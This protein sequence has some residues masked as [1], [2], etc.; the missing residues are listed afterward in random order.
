[1]QSALSQSRE[2]FC[3]REVKAMILNEKRKK[4][5][6]LLAAS[7]V[8]VC[9]LTACGFGK[10]K[11]SAQDNKAAQEQTAAENGTPS[12]GSEIA[13]NSI[14]NFKNDKAYARLKSDMEKGDTP[15][16]CNVLFDVG[17]ARPDVTVTDEAKIKEIYDQLAKI[18]VGEKS[19]RSVTAGKRTI[20]PSPEEAP[21]GTL[22]GACRTL[23]WRKRRKQ[24]L[25]DPP[26]KAPNLPHRLLNR[27][28]PERRQGM[29]G[30]QARRKK[31]NRSWMKSLPT[32]SPRETFRTKISQAAQ[33]RRTRKR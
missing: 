18:T 13:E 2:T 28:L 32:M 4:G 20:M 29:Q 21:C 33:R 27:P 6:R 31:R 24:L 3:R 26:Q 15:I 30:M 12:T 8:V 11:E 1:M 16:E 22:S 5:I 19:N 14:V 17:G 7:A 10:G 25:P 23:P 9:M